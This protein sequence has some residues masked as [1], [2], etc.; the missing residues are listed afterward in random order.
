MAAVVWTLLV[1]TTVKAE[2]KV[3]QEHVPARIIAAHT[4][5]VQAVG[6]SPAG[7]FIATGGWDGTI[8]LWD[9]RTLALKRTLTSPD[10]KITSL[11]FSPNGLLLAAGCVVPQPE[12]FNLGTVLVWEMETG[13][14]LHSITT[15]SSG[16]WGI[17][18]SPDG[19]QIA[20]TGVNCTEVWNAKSGELRLSLQVDRFDDFYGVCFSPDGSVIAAASEDFMGGGNIKIWNAKTGSLIK[21]LADGS[22]VGASVAFVPDGKRLITGGFRELKYWDMASGKLALT[23]KGLSGEVIAVAVSPNGKTVASASG[24]NNKPHGKVDLRLWDAQS[25]KLLGVLS[26]HLQAVLAVA[27]SPDGQFLVSGSDDKTAMVWEIKDSKL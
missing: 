20:S 15:R 17:A 1:P 19:E 24:E 23:S 13:K 5:R 9:T 27:F 22:V 8:N 14:L 6:F 10:A 7:N 11:A 2:P 26:G 3:T 12:K 16:V 25:G 18:F 4:A 21:T